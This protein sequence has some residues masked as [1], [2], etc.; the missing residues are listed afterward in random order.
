[1]GTL[2]VDGY[3][4]PDVDGDAD[5]GDSVNSDDEPD[6][7]GY[8]DYGYFVDPDDETD[9]DGYAELLWWYFFHN[10]YRLCGCLPEATEVSGKLSNT[11]YVFMELGFRYDELS[12]E[13][14]NIIW[15]E[16]N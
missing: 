2:D 4:E 13:G 8:A 14:L 11:Y 9:V 7:D 1:M 6:V 12:C 16:L 15:H 10:C 5:Y 3:D